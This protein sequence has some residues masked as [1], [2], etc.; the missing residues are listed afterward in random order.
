MNARR[1]M[2]LA[3]VASFAGLC[4]AISPHHLR[5]HCDTLDG[6][7]VAD[8]RVALANGDVTPVLKWVTRDFENEVREA[9]SKTL[10]VRKQSLEAKDLADMYF[11]ET[12]VRL[13]RAGEGA[14]YTGLK[15]GGTMDPVIS[16]ADKALESGAIDELASDIGSAVSEQ[17]KAR[18][19]AAS[20]ARK[21]AAESVEA[22]R[23]YVAA[24]V[25]YVHFIEALHE[26][27]TGA[28]AHIGDAQ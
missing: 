15:P 5:A 26:T 18:F 22:G 21:H 28:A 10:A 13:H 25:E 16:A 23:T 4:L 17:V 12:M 11:F 6:P 19:A 7:V 3:M 8:A 27:V 24:Y 20:E 9:F 2:A 1:G 14:P